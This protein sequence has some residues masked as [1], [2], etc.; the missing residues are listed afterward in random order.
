MEAPGVIVQQLPQLNLGICL[1]Q[2]SHLTGGEMGVQGGD[3]GEEEFTPY[4]SLPPNARLPTQFPLPTEGETESGGQNC[5]TLFSF[6][7]LHGMPWDPCSLSS[8]GIRGRWRVRI[9]LGE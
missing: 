4:P 7:G 1:L 5:P 2:S 8:C 9:W 6:Q 3:L